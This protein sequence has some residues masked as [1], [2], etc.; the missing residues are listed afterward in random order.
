MSITVV[1]SARSTRQLEAI[2]RYVAQK[3]SPRIAA[4]Y[5]LRIEARCRSIGHSPYEGTGRDDL[6]P[7]TRST[8]YERRVTIVFRPGESAV[9]ILAILY[10]GQQ[11]ELANLGRRFNP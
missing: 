2:R 3:S 1:F 9:T 11:E 5:V 4:N 7:G 6:S 8:G 10:G